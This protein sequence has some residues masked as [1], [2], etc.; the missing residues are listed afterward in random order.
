MGRAGKTRAKEARTKAW[1]RGGTLRLG[2]GCYKP[3]MG[4]AM[5]QASPA[6][7]F[8]T[9]NMGICLQSLSSPGKGLEQGNSVVP[10]GPPRRRVT[11][12]I[13]N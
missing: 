13:T 6:A 9:V 2:G 12:E 3:D 10:A 4:K 8:C 7:S 5:R 11:D 1:G